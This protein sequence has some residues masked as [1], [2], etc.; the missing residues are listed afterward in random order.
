[1]NPLRKA[2]TFQQA[3]NADEVQKDSRV[4]VRS[5]LQIR[6]RFLER[7]GGK[8]KFA[9]V[10]KFAEKANRKKQGGRP[11]GIRNQTP[12]DIIKA[13]RVSDKPRE[14][15]MIEALGT[16]IQR[17]PRREEA[18]RTAADDHEHQQGRWSRR[19]PRSGKYASVQAYHANLAQA[20]GS[21]AGFFGGISPK[22]M[23]VSWLLLPT[24]SRRPRKKSL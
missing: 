17:C 1:M 13:V 16:G 4:S 24:A 3:G 14:V 5:Y 18:W 6:Q 20:E 15:L 22:H 23:Q 10:K 9:W 8:Q 11:F 12:D 7:I 2:S 19:R 21:K